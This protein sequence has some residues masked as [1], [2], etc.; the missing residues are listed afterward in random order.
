VA[1]WLHAQMGSSAHRGATCASAQP[2]S[3][4]A[5]SQLS[6]LRAFSRVS[7]PMLERLPGRVALL[8]KVRRLLTHGKER[9][10]SKLWNCAPGPIRPRRASAQWHRGC[11]GLLWQPGP[12][13]YVRWREALQRVC[14]VVDEVQEAPE[15][16]CSAAPAIDTLGRPGG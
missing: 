5:L 14:I 15:S 12:G 16:V 7:H 2:Q 4:A 6:Q 3:P 9:A 10:L 11:T 13:M 1:E 8:E